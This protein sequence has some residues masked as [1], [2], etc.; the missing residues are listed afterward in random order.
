MTVKACYERIG[1]DYDDV[2]RRLQNDDKI[3]KFLS[4]L[5]KDKSF[6]DLEAAL[7]EGDIPSAYRASHTFKGIVLNLS[8]SE[9]AESSTELTEALRYQSESIRPLFDKF[10]VLYFR[11]RDAVDALLSDTSKGVEQ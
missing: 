2:I 10:S 6:S 8:L 9:L 4:M 7:A 11:M 3:K 5:L 1:G